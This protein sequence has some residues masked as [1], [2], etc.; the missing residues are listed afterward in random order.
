MLIAMPNLARA[1]G[2]GYGYGYGYPY[3]GGFGYGGYGYMPYGYGSYGY[4]YGG[5]GYP[6]GGFTYPAFGYGY[7]SPGIY[8]PYGAMVYPNINTNPL[9][10]VGL[11]PLGVQSALIERYVLGRGLPG[12]GRVSQSVPSGSSLGGNP[13]GT[14]GR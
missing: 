3:Y 6:Y 10:G 4:P 1:Q 7:L 8:S 11:T 13:P 9:Y 5:F 14:L 12:S 2:F